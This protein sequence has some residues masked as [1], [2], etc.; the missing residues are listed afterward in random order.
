MT[1]ASAYVRI[2]VL[3]EESDSLAR[4]EHAIRQ[5][6]KLRGFDV[7]EVRRDEGVSGVAKV[8]PAYEKWLD[9]ARSGRAKVLLAYHMDRVSR[10]GW[11]RWLP[12]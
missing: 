6:A 2:S 7:V 3:T 9:D 12:S 4:Q 8:R 11:S 5:F 10:G 1:P